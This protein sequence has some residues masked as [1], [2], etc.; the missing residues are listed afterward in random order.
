MLAFAVDCS[1]TANFDHFS[2]QLFARRETRHSDVGGEHAG[3]RL[4]LHVLA[5]CNA[6][7]DLTF[8][9]TSSRNTHTDGRPYRAS[10]NTLRAYAWRAWLDVPSS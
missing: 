7:V 2:R 8:V 4:A 10:S 6:L 5:G 9:F 3:L 1:Q